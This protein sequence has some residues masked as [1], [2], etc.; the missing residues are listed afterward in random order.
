MHISF[1][2]LE[3]RQVL[4]TTFVLLAACPSRP[5]VEAS[6]SEPILTAHEST[7][8]SDNQEVF[9]HGT[10]PRTAQS[11][12]VT[13]VSDMSTSM[14][15]VYVYSPF[16]G[17]G[18]KHLRSPLRYTNGRLRIAITAKG[19]GAKLPFTLHTDDNEPASHRWGFADREG[20]IVVPA[21]YGDAHAY[22]ENLAAVGTVADV[23]NQHS[24]R[25]GAID[26]NGQFVIPPQFE[27]LGMFS[28]GLA[29]FRRGTK[30]GFIDRYGEVRIQPRYGF[31]GHFHDG[32]AVVSERADAVDF[33]V[34]DRRGQ[35]VDIPVPWNYNKLSDRPR[36]DETPTLMPFTDGHLFSYQRVADGSVLGRGAADDSNA[37][38]AALPFS[39]GLGAVDRQRG[40][41]S[42]EYVDE[43][44]N[45]QFTLPCDN[46]VS[47]HDG[48]IVMVY[49]RGSKWAVY[50]EK[51]KL[52]FDT[53]P[54]FDIESTNVSPNSAPVGARRGK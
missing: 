54:E 22:S 23:H 4:S 47:I 5:P 46:P 16:G 39:E 10:S 21:I 6:Q 31:A 34:I 15:S 51:G 29:A 17:D 8:L 45:V 18:T 49:E 27:W 53:L 1:R 25:W 35:R 48:R 32:Y 9:E 52:V 13:E 44:L 2:H 3:G 14:P 28:D 43:Y 37:F 36:W 41:G 38:E 40:D 7:N 26:V 24:R 20:K 42:C 30:F 12:I 33:L 19:E 50:D 11:P